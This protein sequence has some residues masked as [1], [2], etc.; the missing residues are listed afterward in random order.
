M[1]LFGK[2]MSDAIRAAVWTDFVLIVVWVLI[3]AGV[4]WYGFL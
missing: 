2:M 4:V 3:G 1:R